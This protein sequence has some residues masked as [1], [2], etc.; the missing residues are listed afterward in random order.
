MK[1]ECKITV[2]PEIRSNNRAV[3]IAQ[4]GG[5][6]CPKSRLGVLSDTVIRQVEKQKQYIKHF[7]IKH[8]H[9]YRSNFEKRTH[10]EQTSN[11][12]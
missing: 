6:A 8:R 4:V 12:K 9:S 5:K 3:Q 1:L 10:G 11:F 7:F 2:V